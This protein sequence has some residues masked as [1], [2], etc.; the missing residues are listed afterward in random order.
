MHLDLICFA[1]V[2]RHAMGDIPNNPDDVQS[3]FCCCELH[4][5]SATLVGWQHLASSLQNNYRVLVFN[6][7]LCHSYIIPV[8]HTSCI[9]VFGSRVSREF[10][11]RACP[12]GIL[13]HWDLIFPLVDELKRTFLVLKLLDV[14]CDEPVEPSC[15]WPVCIGC[16]C[17]F[18][19]GVLFTASSVDDMNV[20]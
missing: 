7:F 4:A 19:V 16:A 2:N 6:S 14:V 9:A 10:F 12:S 13:L 20:F 1:P 18:F 5:H 8:F 3:I 15:I 17:G 11:A